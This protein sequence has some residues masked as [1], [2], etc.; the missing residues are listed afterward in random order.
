MTM[1]AGSRTARRNRCSMAREAARTST[2]IGAHAGDEASSGG[3]S[4][5]SVCGEQGERISLGCCWV[6]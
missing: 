6:V 4:E 5:A 1:V 3:G 2:G